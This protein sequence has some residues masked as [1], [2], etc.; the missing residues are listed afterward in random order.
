MG[1]RQF[2]T[3][4]I[5]RQ[6]RATPLQRVEFHDREFDEG[7]LQQLLFTHPQILPIAEIEPVF[8]RPLALAREVPTARGPIDLLLV[9]PDGFLTVLETKLW[10]N[11]EQR[12]KVIAQ[13]LEY[14]KA[15]SEF[16][17]SRLAEALKQ[18][19]IVAGDR[20]NPL[21]SVVET[22]EEFDQSAFFD[23][24]GRNLQQGQHLLLIVGD[25]IQEELEELS[26]F[27][28]RTPELGHRLAL[29]ELAAY[30]ESRSPDSTLYVQPRIVART[31][32]V[33]RAVVEVR[34]PHKPTEV[35]V[36]L[37]PA[38]GLKKGRAPIT[39][40]VFY[41]ELGRLAGNVATDFAAW[42]VAHAGR[43]GL[44]IDWKEAGPVVKYVDPENAYFFTLG[45]LN[46]HGTLTETYRFYERCR[47]LN[48]PP[49]IWQEYFD[50]VAGIVPGAKRKAFRTGGKGQEYEQI[51]YG[52]NP[53]PTDFV[54]LTALAPHKE[55]WLAVIERTVERIRKALD[56]R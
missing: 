47:E 23:R 39:E 4:L 50:E 31:R 30:R 45:Q 12:R 19:K 52:H 28:H 34:P 24:L 26:E 13:I 38:E 2:G 40:R 18:A 14:A 41:D 48:L 25:G 21:L 36:T 1:Q 44:E 54:P 8:D 5:I 3:P 56:T 42:V 49:E 43:H 20:Q 15:L 9:N 17:C 16:S 55:Q 6:G 53:G 35:V 29:V 33:V 37:P 46:R 10:R 22:A 7:W 32:E 11:P 51:V 27:L